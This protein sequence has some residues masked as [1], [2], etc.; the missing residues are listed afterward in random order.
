MLS[1]NSTRLFLALPLVGPMNIGTMIFQATGKAK[2]AF[3]TAF[4]R[5]VVFLI[6]SAFLWTHL[7]K[8]KGV[9]LAFPSSDVLTFL[10]VALLM[11]PILKEFRNG[12]GQDLAIA[13]Q[14][15]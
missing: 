9:W 8:L 4:G 10:L 1:L 15:G 6:P 14:Q 11:L 3:I 2:Q 12:A 7:L 13:G 5:P